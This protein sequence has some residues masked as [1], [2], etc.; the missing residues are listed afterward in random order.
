M[1]RTIATTGAG[2]ACVAA[3]ATAATAQAREERRWTQP[4]ETTQSALELA[5]G[6]G[7]TQGLGQLTPARGFGDTSGGGVAVALDVNY[8]FQPRWSLGLQ[9]EYDELDPR[10]DTWARGFASNAGVTYHARPWS[11]GDPWVRLGTGYR[12]FGAAGSDKTL[13]HAFELARATVGYDF[14]VDSHI[15]FAPVLGVDVDL[16]DWQYA[17]SVHALSGFARP[18]LGGFVFAGLQARLDVGG[19]AESSSR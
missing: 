7:F 14:R 11:S 8:R 16:S 9:F 12:M 3:L 1:T 17:F 2:L 10:N 15:A 5:V 19:Q 6:S 18:Q 4:P 13:I